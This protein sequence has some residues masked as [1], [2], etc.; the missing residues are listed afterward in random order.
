MFESIYESSDGFSLFLL[1]H[2][3][4]L[5]SDIESFWFARLS[6]EK[7]KILDIIQLNL[8]RWLQ[9][10]TEWSQFSSFILIQMKSNRFTQER[11]GRQGEISIEWLQYYVE[12]T[13]GS[14]LPS[15]LNR[16][17]KIIEYNC[18]MNFFFSWIVAFRQQH[19]NC[20]RV[21]SSIFTTDSYVRVP[22][23]F[24]K[25]S[26]GPRRIG[27]PA[28][29][30]LAASFGIILEKGDSTWQSNRITFNQ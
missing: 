22:I 26:L 19:S 1:F 15:R 11:W 21:H 14:R 28:F 16:D 12:I 23:N 3:E 4:N 2:F 30:K 8:P 5:N 13:R 7:I 17:W 29:L 18:S 6:D 9:F 24:R 20:F 27:W 10:D 25:A